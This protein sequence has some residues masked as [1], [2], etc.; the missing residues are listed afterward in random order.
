MAILFGKKSI[1]FIEFLVIN[2]DFALTPLI[3]R[4]KS[5]SKNLCNNCLGITGNL[6]NW[7]Y[8]YRL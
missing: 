8:T 7:V 5:F 4:V 1:E 6:V 2:G 3:L